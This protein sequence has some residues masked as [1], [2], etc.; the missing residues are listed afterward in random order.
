VTIDK[1][2]MLLMQERQLTAEESH[3]L[4]TA[5]GQILLMPLPFNKF[6]FFGICFAIYL[7]W[8]GGAMVGMAA[9]FFSQLGGSSE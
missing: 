8:R 2:L 4:E 6:S 7:D 9:P 1:R 5:A 3:K